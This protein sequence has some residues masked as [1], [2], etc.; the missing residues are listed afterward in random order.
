M[1][2]CCNGSNSDEGNL[3]AT[4]QKSDLVS[5]H[6]VYGF[7]DDDVLDLVH[8]DERGGLSARGVAGGHLDAQGADD[9]QGFPVNLHKVDVKGHAEQGDEDGAGQD[10][11]V[12]QKKEHAHMET[13]SHIIIVLLLLIASN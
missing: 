1:I 11:C 10:S 7:V 2:C 3:E 13:T 6:H 9:Q 5:S 8:L 4:L 12:L